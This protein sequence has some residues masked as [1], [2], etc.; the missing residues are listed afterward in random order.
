MRPSTETSTTWCAH[1][2]GIVRE[3]RGCRSASRRLGKAGFWLGMNEPEAA[4]HGKNIVILL[5]FPRSNQGA[6]L[7]PWAFHLRQVSCL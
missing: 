4:D 1:H 3:A 2:P 6:T 7:L 5:D